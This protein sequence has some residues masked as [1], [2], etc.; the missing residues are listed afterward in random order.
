[1]RS[2][3]S[4][5]PLRFTRSAG[6]GPAPPHSARRALARSSVSPSRSRPR[7]RPSGALARST[8]AAWPP[9]PTVPST[10]VPPG[11]T[12]RSSSA[13]ARRTGTWPASDPMLREEPPVL[14][15]E[16]LLLE[17]P[18]LQALQVPHR[19]VVLQ[20]EDAHFARHGRAFAPPRRGPDA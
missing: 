1:M 17:Q 7:R 15:G 10:Y 4:L 9:R 11:L 13:S 12:A 18:L 19:E 8:A 3:S 6:G 14:V 16:R 2:A 20:A 5:S